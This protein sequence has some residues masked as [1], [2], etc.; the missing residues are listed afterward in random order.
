[1]MCSDEIAPM[2]WP[3]SKWAVLPQRQSLCNPDILP[4]TEQDSIMCLWTANWSVQLW[5]KHIAPVFA[6]FLFSLKP[7]AAIGIDPGWLLLLMSWFSVLGHSAMEWGS[8][9][10]GFCLCGHYF[11]HSTQLPPVIKES[12]GVV[13]SQVRKSIKY[14]R[15]P[16]WC[17]M[18]G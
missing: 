11:L 12:M 1:M 7:C 9:A 15:V 16:L 17:L 5:K 4:R 14:L 3:L 13:S 18:Q 10:P 6:S 2:S 8:E